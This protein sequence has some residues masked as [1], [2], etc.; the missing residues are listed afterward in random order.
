MAE[1]KYS[2]I[3][4]DIS[5]FGS[6][7]EPVKH[8]S[9]EEA[10]KL[11]QKL[12]KSDVSKDRFG[13]ALSIP[14]DKVFGEWTEEGI[15]IAVL[16]GEQKV[17][18]G[19]FGETFITQ[20]KEK[21][22]RSR[23]YI[24]AYK[25]LY[26]VF[27]NARKENSESYDVVHPDFLFAKENELFEQ[28]EVE[29]KEQENKIHPKDNESD[30]ELYNES[31]EYYKN[32]ISVSDY[33]RFNLM[34]EDIKKER[35]YFSKYNEK[36]GSHKRL[37]ELKAKEDFINSFSEEYKRIYE[38]TFKDKEI[39]KPAT[40]EEILSVMEFTPE[41][42]EDG[43][44]KVYDQQRN[45]YLDNHSDLPSF[46][47]DK[48]TFTSAA[49][50]FERMDIYINDYYI[51]D[52]QEQL[53]GVGI[54][55]T[56]NETLSDLCKLYQSE[57]EKGNDKLSIGE[58]NLAMG[59]VHPETVILR[60]EVIKQEQSNNNS[61][62]ENEIYPEFLLYGDTPDEKIVELKKHLSMNGYDIKWKDKT[63][64]N[65]F[66]EFICSIDDKSYI[67]T[68]LDDRGIDYGYELGLLATGYDAA[69]LNE[70]EVLDAEV[71]TKEEFKRINEIR[72][73]EFKDLKLPYIKIDFT[74]GSTSNHK[75]ARMESGTVLGLKESEELLKELNNRF[76][77]FLK[78][79]I[80]VYFPDAK[81]N[82]PGSY[83]LRYDFCNDK[84]TLD[85]CNI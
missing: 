31:F 36:E 74:E 44:I 34:L 38:E 33:P 5:E 23:T 12:N 25:E 54:E 80:T 4:K 84:R 35:E 18:F 48:W 37:L 15:C 64:D 83:S 3:V 16:N 29:S 71:V 9:A 75:P 52:M 14:G 51:H 50:I 19:I 77:T 28:I 66:T 53:E 10:V 41:F 61:I 60:E 62:Q 58:L 40:L 32:S 63:E 43:K 20:L 78:C 21:N 68:I 69:W 59:I 49:E 47:E 46:D 76:N 67:Q 85:N 22:E 13:I 7:F 70:D 57:L 2:F 55:I 73:K 1:K 17:D 30:V 45:E 81:D 39:I 6:D 27:E 79:D 82:E 8:L 56:G 26:T 42:T 72:E 65:N 11:F 24:D